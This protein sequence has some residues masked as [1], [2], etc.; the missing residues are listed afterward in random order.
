V[1]IYHPL[2]ATEEELAPFRQQVEILDFLESQFGPYPFESA[3]ACS[4]TSRSAGARVPDDA[5]YSRGIRTPRW[6]RGASSTS[7]RTSGSATR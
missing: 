6:A 2:D 3:A 7:S 5:V 4:R 1:V